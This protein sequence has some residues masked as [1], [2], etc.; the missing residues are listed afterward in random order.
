MIPSVEIKFEGKSNWGLLDLRSILVNRK[1]IGLPWRI[2]HT[3]ELMGFY[4]WI[5]AFLTFS[6]PAS[7][8]EI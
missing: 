7:I 6:K 3:A 8:L 4:T 1:V 2:L 5:V